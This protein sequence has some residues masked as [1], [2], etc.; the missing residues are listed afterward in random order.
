M[1]KMKKN[2]ERE[3]KSRREKLFRIG[4]HFDINWIEKWPPAIH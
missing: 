4:S 2:W 1:N 3:V